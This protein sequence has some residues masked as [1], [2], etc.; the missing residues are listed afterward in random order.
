[1]EPWRLGL[2]V[3][4]RRGRSLLLLLVKVGLLD[5]LLFLHQLL[6]LRDGG[7]LHALGIRGGLHLCLDILQRSSS[8][9]RG[10]LRLSDGDA[11]RL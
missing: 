11:G 10:W 5:V 2:R 8:S 6:S 4:S 9:L 1:M 7:I 3:H